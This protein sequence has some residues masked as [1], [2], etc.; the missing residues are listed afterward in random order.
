[1]RVPRVKTG[2]ES[3]ASRGT[4]RGPNPAQLARLKRG[5]FYFF[6]FVVTFTPLMVATSRALH[7][8]VFKPACTA[9]GTPRGLTLLGFTAGAGELLGSPSYSSASCNFGGRFNRVW[10]HDIATP[11]TVWLERFSGFVV[12]VAGVLGGLLIV[13]LV[14]WI[15]ET[16]HARGSSPPRH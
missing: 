12:V 8:W 7:E 11:K 5:A 1:M 4:P 15:T 2:N 13:G 16:V 6:L 3:D 9:W 10:L 14:A